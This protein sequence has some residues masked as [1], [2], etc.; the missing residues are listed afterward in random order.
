MNQTKIFL[1]FLR[2]AVL[3]GVIG[4]LALGTLGW[5]TVLLVWGVLGAI[6]EFIHQGVDGALLGIATGIIYAFLR[7]DKPESAAVAALY[8]GVICFIYKIDAT[9]V[10]SI[11]NSDQYGA[12][13]FWVLDIPAAIWVLYI[14]TR[15]YRTLTCSGP[16]DLRKCLRALVPLFF[17]L[18][19]FPVNVVMSIRAGGAELE[20]LRRVQAEMP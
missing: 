6:I 4:A 19:L 7:I 1:I 17:L 12:V 13:M 14:V 9:I 5:V 11:E 10:F 16:S 3:G 2:Y 18:V 8:G 15:A 20:D